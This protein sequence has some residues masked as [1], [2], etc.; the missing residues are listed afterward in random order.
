L[1]LVDGALG[2]PYYLGEFPLSACGVRVS[3]PS[4]EAGE[5]GAQVLAD[6]AELARAMAILDAILAAK[7]PGWQR[8]AECVGDGELLNSEKDKRRR[9][10]LAA[11]RVDFSLLSN[12]EEDEDED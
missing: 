11:T 2:E 6:D 8:A 7:L 4:G 12:A 10:M 1:S 5:G 3:F 9:S